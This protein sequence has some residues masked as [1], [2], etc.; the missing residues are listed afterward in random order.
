MNDDV[1]MRG[2]LTKQNSKR[3]IN[4]RGREVM[5]ERNKSQL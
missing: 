1:Y 2:K 4:S 5:Q 3:I